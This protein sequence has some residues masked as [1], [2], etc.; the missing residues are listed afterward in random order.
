MDRL[1]TYI[2]R[3]DN[4]VLSNATFKGF[5]N[6]TH[7][8]FLINKLL[9]ILKHLVIKSYTMHHMNIYT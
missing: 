6:I 9:Y 8:P 3:V 1:N 7:F 5:L 4:I 2:T